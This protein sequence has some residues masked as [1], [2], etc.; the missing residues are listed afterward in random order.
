MADLAI[1]YAYRY[2]AASRLD[3]TADPTLHLA[4]AGGP[5]EHPRLF[6][7]RVV[8]PV[9]FSDALL[10]VGA[11]ARS[12][13]HVPAAMLGRILLL[14]DPVATAS[15]D[16][17]R[18]EA[19]S[20]CASVYVRLDLLPGFVDGTFLGSGTTNVDLGAD[21][22]AALAGVTDAARLDLELGTDDLAVEVDGER[23]EERRVAL[24]E[25]WVR[26][27][28]ETQAILAG[29]D[30]RFVVDGAAFRRFL[31][32]L[33]RGAR[34]PVFVTEVG[35]RAVLARRPELGAV[36]VADADRLRVLERLAA[37]VRSVTVYAAGDGA[38][39]WSAELDDARLTR[40]ISAAAWRGFSGEGRVLDA[41]ARPAGRRVRA[42]VEAALAWQAEV[43]AGELAAELGAG[44]PDVEAVLADLAAAG[45]VGYD[46][47]E[48][49]YFARRLPFVPPGARRE[50]PRLRQARAL[51][52]AG[53]VRVEAAGDDASGVVA[54]VTGRSAEYRVR[55]GP[56]GRACTCP[57]WG[58]HPGD[59]GPCAHILAAELVT[60]ADAGAPGRRVDA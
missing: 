2:G 31:R 27:F 44:V 60:A 21:V 41:L 8:H 11:V 25:R 3:D 22:R 7:G 45:V 13:F 58:K 48:H 34:D 42:A 36:A 16:R 9:L 26:G 33:P 49:G 39:A 35:G 37:S 5:A 1:D 6:R 28:A 57:W 23:H 29:M 46:L 18:F 30:R 15:H 59:R 53:A 17:L 12:R 56:D 32:D 24:P 47:A 38:S 50:Q 19:F 14:A 52:E 40:A 54:W 10:A 51:V 20:S 55:L 4:T 43:R